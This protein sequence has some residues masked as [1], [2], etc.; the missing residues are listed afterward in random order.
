[1]TS[2]NDILFTQ[3]LNNVNSPATVELESRIQFVTP[4]HNPQPQ[5]LIEHTLGFCSHNKHKDYF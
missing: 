1:M 4:M 5:Q 2:I 3:L